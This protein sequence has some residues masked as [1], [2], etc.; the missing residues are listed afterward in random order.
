MYIKI[1]TSEKKSVFSLL[2][3]TF[4]HPLREENVL[5]CCQGGVGGVPRIKLRL[6]I[7][8]TVECHC[9]V[10][11]GLQ[12]SSEGF[13]CHCRCHVMFWVLFFSSCLVFR[14]CYVFP[15]HIIR[16]L[17]HSCTPSPITSPQYLV[18]RFSSVL[19]KILTFL[20]HFMPWVLC[21]SGFV[22]S[23]FCLSFLHS[24]SYCCF[25]TV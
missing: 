24:H 9:V 25:F 17:F 21:S 7:G 16:S 2:G 11:S 18:S 4:T 12:I 3:C 10:W 19:C 6:N 13:K 1:V 23:G 5:I 8:W 15:F 20:P 22:M 14:F